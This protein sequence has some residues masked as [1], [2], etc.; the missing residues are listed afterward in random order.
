MERLGEPLRLDAVALLLLSLGELLDLPPLDDVVL[1]RVAV[2]LVPGQHHPPAD[3]VVHLLLVQGLLVHPLQQG[4]LGRGP[5]GLGQV[6]S[7]P[8]V[9]GTELGDSLPVGQSRGGQRGRAAEEDRLRWER[10]ATCRR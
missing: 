3:V 10:E 1:L 4:V 6:V 7:S 2:Q 8:F 5:E 9:D